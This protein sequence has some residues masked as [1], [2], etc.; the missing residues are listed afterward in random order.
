MR[1]EERLF[2]AL[3]SVDDRL[4]ERSEGTRTRPW[5][6]VALAAAACVALAAAVT[7][8]RL[9][10]EQPEKPPEELTQETEVQSLRFNGGEVGELHLC[11]IRYGPR[12]SA[13]FAIYVNEELYTTSEEDGVYTIR[14]R[15]TLP[16]DEFPPIDL[17]VTH[18]ETLTKAEAMEA[19]ARTLAK[20]YA[21]VS[22]AEEEGDHLFL[23]AGDGT[24]WNAA[25][26]AVTCF[27]DGDGGSF[28]L[29]ARY[30]TEAAEGHGV[31][32]RDMAGTFT[33]VY[34]GRATSPPWVGELQNVTKRLAEAIF[35][36]RTD[37]IADLLA[38]GASVNGYGADVSGEISVASMDYMPDNDQEPSS[39][40]VSVKCRTNTEEGYDYL[41]MELCRTG[42]KWLLT[43]AGIEK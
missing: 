10:Q 4:L 12:P 36:D 29:T 15:D 40:T 33:V 17:T 30:F 8:P 25:Q 18:A 11:S 39:A 13:G 20:V 41:T 28:T 7:L 5:P 42:G 24:A 19:A 38:E 43:W 14:P 27:D 31:R 34:E 2:A 16:E 35:A 32:F 3:N 9:S 26:A 6:W 37:T 21:Q 23:T 1:K 22:E